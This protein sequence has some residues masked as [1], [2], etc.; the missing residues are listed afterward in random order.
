MCDKYKHF[1]YLAGFT[2]SILLSCYMLCYTIL[3][4]FYA[5]HIDIKLQTKELQLPIEYWPGFYT[6]LKIIWQLL[7]IINSRNCAMVPVKYILALD[8]QLFL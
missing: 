8:G 4:L 5:V 2:S 6:Q 1:V 7:C 3:D